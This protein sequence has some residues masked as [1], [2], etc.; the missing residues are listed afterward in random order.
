M[1][2]AQLVFILIL[3]FAFLTIAASCLKHAIILSSVMGLWASLAYLLYHA[4]DVA[5]SEAVVA[6]TLGTIMLV[7]TIRKYSDITLPPLRELV[8]IRWWAAVMLA[9]TCGL[10][11][12][13]TVSNPGISQSPLHAAVM[14][15]Y[16]DSPR[17]VN[18]ISSILLDFR[19][20][21]TVLEASMLLVAVLAV[22]HLTDTSGH[23]G[24]TSYPATNLSHPTLRTGI[25]VILPLFVVIGLALVAGD[26]F[27]P[28]GGFQGGG[29]LAAVV[30]G[31]YLIRPYG[32][33]RTKAMEN[34]EKIV[35]VT[36]VLSVM[37]YYA[38]SL[39]SDFTYPIFMIAMNTLLG[40]KVFCGLSI[41]FLFFAAEE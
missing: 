1:V 14:Q 31:R 16:L 35:F 28:G 18:P 22:V 26:P 38:L 5:I 6:S 11:I 39:R 2:L 15:A 24:A 7:L 33:G 13:Y 40:I 17:I 32:G 30:V 19:V 37:G 34:I 10:M 8:R 4:P 27:T 9:L 36:F 21:D 25:R 3:A 41:I 20:F 23:H 29:V 12:W